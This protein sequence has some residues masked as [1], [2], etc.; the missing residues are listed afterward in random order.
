MLNTFTDRPSIGIASSI[1]NWKMKKKLYET[2]VTQSQ[3]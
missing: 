3:I 2:N 1:L